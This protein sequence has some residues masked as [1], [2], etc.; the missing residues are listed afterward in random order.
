MRHQMTVN[1]TTQAD[2]LHAAGEW[3][4]AAGLFADAERRQRELQPEYW[5]LYSVQGYRYCNC[6]SHRGEATAA[7]DRTVQTSKWTRQHPDLL[8]GVLDSLTLSRANLALA[9]R[10]LAAQSSAGTPP[11]NASVA[12]ATFQKNSEGLR[13]LGTQ[14]L[15]NSWPHRPRRVSP[16]N[17]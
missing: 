3:E 11:S 16:H 10:N 17:R 4:K 2:A 6:C 1:R 13:D 8:T 7:R 5:V 14:R 9:L 15:P 12:S